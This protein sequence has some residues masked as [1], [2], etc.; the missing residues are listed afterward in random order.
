MCAG[1]RLVHACFLKI[2]SVQMFVCV[3][4]CICVYVTR[5]VLIRLHKKRKQAYIHL[6]NCMKDRKVCVD[7]NKFDLGKNG[8]HRPSD[9]GGR[10]TVMVR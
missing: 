9:L 3:F 8:R 10:L 1:H 6:R 7:E 2:V 4:L 5:L